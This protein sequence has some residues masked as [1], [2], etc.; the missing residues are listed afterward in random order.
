MV[1]GETLTANAPLPSEGVYPPRLIYDEQ[2]QVI[3]VILAY[4]DY[5]TYLRILAR[6]ADWESLPGYLQDAVDNML[7]DEALQESGPSTSLEELLAA[8]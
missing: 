4:G 3:G 8:G 5:Q 1:P 7:A 6:Y 2:G